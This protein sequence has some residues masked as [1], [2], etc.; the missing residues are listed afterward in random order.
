MA[1]I[2]YGTPVGRSGASPYQ[3]DYSGNY[4]LDTARGLIDG[5]TA[6]HKF[7]LA[8]D[9]DVA[10]GDVTI[11]DGVANDLDIGLIPNYT[12]STQAD[13]AQ[14]VSTN[15]TDDTTIYIEGLDAEG[16][17]VTQMVSLAGHTVATLPTPLFRV[18]RMYNANGHE[19]L[20]DVYLSATGQTYTNGVPLSTS[21]IRSIMHNE[22][23][24]TAQAIYSVPSDSDLFITHGWASIGKP[25]TTEVIVTIWKRSWGG[26]FRKVHTLALSS[27]GT[28]TDHR[29]YEVPIVM[30][31]GTD[32]VYKCQAFSNNTTVSAG[33]HGIVVKN[34]EKIPGYGPNE[35]VISE[36]VDGVGD[37][38]VDSTPDILTTEEEIF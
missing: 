4:Y 37:Q 20:G 11:W 13:I 7:G 1:T 3:G 22:N 35:I 36:L 19:H 16:K 26:V 23:Q 33:F 6:I 14:L 9:V 31:A 34:G 30:E 25:T 32:L 29:T 5:S 18:N 24:Q 27:I 10:E 21:L 12:F 8:E 15:D 28:G 17:E 38:L 2:L